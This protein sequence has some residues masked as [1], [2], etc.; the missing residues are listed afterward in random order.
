MAW[1]GKGERIAVIAVMG[2][3]GRCATRRGPWRDREMYSTGWI[4]K[5]GRGGRLRGG[6]S[7][8]MGYA[9]EETG[10]RTGGR[11]SSGFVSGS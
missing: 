6:V 9:S 5:E 11:T 4:G 7:A 2:A 8:G 10:R 1:Q 3:C